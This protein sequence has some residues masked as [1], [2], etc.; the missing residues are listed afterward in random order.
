M[1]RGGETEGEG[2]RGEE[3]ERSCKEERGE[4]GQRGEDENRE[5]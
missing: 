5:L 1:L 3:R 2:R 4:H